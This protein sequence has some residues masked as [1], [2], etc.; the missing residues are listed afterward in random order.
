MKVCSTIGYE[1]SHNK[2]L[3]LGDESRFVHQAISTL[4]P[5]PPNFQAIVAL[6]RGPLL[7]HA[8]EGQPL[9]PRQVEVKRSE[10]ALLVDIR[11]DVQFDDAHIPD[12][13]CNP[14]VRAGFGTK[15]AWV[16]DREQEVV[17]L[18]RYDD[19]GIHAAHLAAAVG[20]TNIGGHLAG[21]MT[22]W[23]E[24][25]RPMQSVQRIDVEEL[26]RRIDRLQVLDVRERSEWDEGHVPG[27]VHAPYHE[28]TAIPDGIDPGSPIAVMCSSG[29]RSALA[30]SLLLRHGARQVLH[31]AD[32]GVGTWKGHGWDIE[33]GE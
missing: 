19:D 21:G 4:A 6:N 22:S 17:F 2:L 28:I 15:L 26:R 20:I 25:K 13:V 23:R 10:G 5:Q 7:T 8:V 31:V 18:G 11:T 24:E 33:D 16:A 1:R 12:A 30:A 32:G 3:Q 14:V 29:Q 9:T 27:S